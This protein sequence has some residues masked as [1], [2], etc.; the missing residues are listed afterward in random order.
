MCIAAYSLFGNAQ[1]QIKFESEYF[2]DSIIAGNPKLTFERLIPY[3][4]NQEIEERHRKAGL[5]LWY[6]VE[7]PVEKFEGKKGIKH[8]RATKLIEMPD[9]PIIPVE[10]P[11][12]TSKSTRS[13]SMNDPLY[14]KQWHYYDS[15]PGAIRLDKAWEKEEGNPNVLVAVMDQWIDYTHPDLAANMW[16][17]RVEQ[18][19]LPNVDDDGNGYVDDIHGLNLTG[20]S[21]F[22]DHATHVAGTIA[23]VNNNGIGVCGIAGGNGNDTGV[24][25]MSVGICLGSEDIVEDYM[26]A[27]GYVYAADMGA[28]IS[29]NSW[30]TPNDEQAEIILE[31]IEYFMKNSGQYEGSPM[32]GG[33]VVFGAANDG[34]EKTPF[35]ISGLLADR[36]NLI[37]VASVG[38]NGMRSTFS[39]YGDWVDISAPGGEADGKGVYSTYTENRYGFQNGTSMACPHVSGVAAL[40]VSKFGGASLTP[41][42]VKDII[43]K[44]SAE[45]DKY[46][47][48]YPYAG[49]L[50]AGILNADAALN[51]NPQT[52]PDSPKSFRVTRDSQ[53]RTYFEW[54]VPL[55][56]NGSPVAYCAVYADGT[57]K[58]LFTAKTSSSEEFCVVVRDVEASS[59]TVQAIDAF[60]NRS[61]HSIKTYTEEISVPAI[62][63][64]YNNSNVIVH[65]PSVYRPGD[66]Y[67][68]ALP[69]CE[70][71]LFCA[72][73]ESYSVEEPNNI[74]SS[75][76]N[77]SSDVLCLRFNA[78]PTTPLGDYP[79]TV[80]YGVPGNEDK[81]LE[82][83][84]SILPA[85]DN[86]T[87]PI[88]NPDKA[89]IYTS[90]FEGTIE[91]NLR[92][93]IYDPLGLDFIIPDAVIELDYL[94]DELAEYFDAEVI[95]EKLKIKYRFNDEYLWDTGTY[96]PFVVKTINSYLVEGSATFLLH[97]IEETNIGEITTDGIH[98]QDIYNMQGM[99]QNNDLQNLKP[100]IY[101][102]KGSKRKVIL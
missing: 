61:H 66:S 31:G 35:P 9:V 20:K 88:A 67:D 10:S 98:R 76:Y 85:H 7:A 32:N 5:H 24:K 22:G 97:Y 40:V 47:I 37:V 72:N 21:E 62:K 25:L 56:A 33:L 49:K 51:S 83:R 63:N 27:R 84:Y 30:K 68:Y 2:A 86:I 8:V 58:P 60:G 28:I 55:D 53:R 50:G 42:Q 45:V 65:Y 19:G 80:K 11:V 71:N 74:V 89:H 102:I 43:I 57:D 96:I 13:V 54:D 90:D 38:S 29:S 59:F 36:G 77:D 44:S 69:V 12:I 75:F 52:A 73:V 93:Y 101:I 99:K 91:M 82:L 6:L 16:V 64:T 46:Q 95:N 79:L 34:S 18:D 4:P 87:G 92:D 70:V 23:A 1:T 17:N 78:T 81:S 41:S 3:A 94:N 39:N 15:C 26:L 48:G 14:E 100:G